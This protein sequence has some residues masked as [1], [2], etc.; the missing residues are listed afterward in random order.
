MANARWGPVLRRVR[1]LI[2][3][4]TVAGVPDRELLDRYTGG[5]PESAERAF[6][7]LVDRHGPMVLKTCRAVLREEHAAHDAFQATFLVLSRRAASLWVVESLAPWLHGVAVRTS[8]SARNAAARRRRHE[9]RAGEM[10]RREAA[11]APAPDDRG[12]IIHQEI[13]RL[14]ERYR[15]AIVLC[16]LDGLTHEQA[17][18]RL[19]CP[20]GTIRSR[21]AAGRDRLR[22]RLIL[23]G[24]SPEADV[25]EPA[26]SGEPTPA[27]PAGLVAST[28][29]IGTL[30]TAAAAGTVP[31]PVA[32]LARVE[33]T[34]MMLARLRIGAV[35]LIVAAGAGTAGALALAQRPEAPAGANPAGIPA[36]A[37]P[38]TPRA[39]AALPPASRRILESRVETA[40][41][42]IKQDMS[43]L[44]HLAGDPLDLFPQIPT[45]SRRLM[46]DRLRLAGTPADRLEAIREHRNRMLFMEGLVGQYARS[47]Q[48]RLADALRARYDRLEA[49]QLLSEAGVDPDR[50]PAPETQK[51]D[52][53]IAPP[54]PPP[55]PSRRP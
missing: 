51:A 35:G 34:T 39:D 52:R 47:G 33:L 25:L 5:S 30:S 48:G 40:R 18:E 14:P 27:I 37:N 16:Y 17:A 6:A 42:I 2:D 32:A 3:D 1:H 13:D 22:R 53:G 28:I 11:D 19:G 55:P 44:Q 43:R 45:W 10:S 50:E 36:G 31:A 41:E 21:L 38:T 12:P 29:R 20:V 24:L 23:R 54:P 4:G 26:R 9:N 15:V 8:W 49:D 46:E 7:A